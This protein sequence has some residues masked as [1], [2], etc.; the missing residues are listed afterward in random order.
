MGLMLGYLHLLVTPVPGE[1]GNDTGSTIRG[2]WDNLRENGYQTG[3][4]LIVATVAIIALVNIKAKPYVSVP[5]TIGA[6]WA[7]WLGWNTFTRQ[8]NP[9]FPGDV[10]ALELWDIA[11]ESDTSFLVVVIVACAAAVFVWRK[12]VSGLGK[13]ALVV[14]VVLGASFV[15]NIVQS[16]RTT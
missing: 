10:R 9:L 5:V 1:P 14:G 13:I 7:G 3:T 4:A 12:S 16:V 2:V 8:N 11:F 6:F 15:Y